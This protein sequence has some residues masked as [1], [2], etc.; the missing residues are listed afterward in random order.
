MPLRDEYAEQI[1]RVMALDP[2]PD[3]VKRLE[4]ASIDQLELWKNCKGQSKEL[5]CA[6]FLRYRSWAEALL[7]D[8][9]NAKN[10]IVLGVD[11]EEALQDSINSIKVFIGVQNIMAEPEGIDDDDDDDDD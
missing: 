9:A 10:R 5:F 2:R 4:K 11:P 8:V 3:Q 6:T 7:S 1:E